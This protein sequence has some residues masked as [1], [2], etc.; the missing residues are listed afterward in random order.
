MLE[1]LGF[2]DIN[3]P[4]A[5]KAHFDEFR[6]GQPHVTIP[7]LDTTINP[8]HTCAENLLLLK[9]KSLPRTDSN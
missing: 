8:S 7:S 2:H 6:V 1:M 9:P 3:N 5:K 4:L